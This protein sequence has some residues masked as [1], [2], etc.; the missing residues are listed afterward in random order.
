MALKLRNPA[1][2]L[3]KFDVMTIDHLPSAFFRGG[4]VIAD[5][6]DGFH[7]VAITAD[8]VSS[9]VRRNRDSLTPSA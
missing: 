6:I 1:V 3:P 9:I 5:E 7:E 4:V 8:K 2:V